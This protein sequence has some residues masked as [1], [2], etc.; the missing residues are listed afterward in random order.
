MFLLFTI[1]SH[2]SPLMC[3]WREPWGQNCSHS[4]VFFGGAKSWQAPVSIGMQPSYWQGFEQKL[5]NINLKINEQHDETYFFNYIEYSCCVCLAWILLH[6]ILNQ[7]SMWDARWW[8][9]LWTSGWRRADLPW[10]MPIY[11]S[12]SI[13]Q[14]A[15]YRIQWSTYYGRFSSHVYMAPNNKKFQLIEFFCA[16]CQTMICTWYTTTPKGNDTIGSMVNMSW[17][18]C[19]WVVN[20][21]SICIFSYLWSKCGD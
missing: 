17:H 3:C 4:S 15:R 1:L 13:H 19:W 9:W 5:S 14:I 20:R 10:V 12:V 21:F 16:P 7:V 8:Y 6:V 2:E 11:F 18:L